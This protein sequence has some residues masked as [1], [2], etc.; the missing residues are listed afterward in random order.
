MRLLP[1]AARWWAV[2]ALMPWLAF[3]ASAHG[4]G[5]ANRYS[6]DANSLAGLIAENYAYLD[7][8]PGGAVLATPQLEAERLGVHD[9]DSL[10]HYAEDVITTL[11]DHH[12]LTGSSFSD[13][14][15]IVPSYSDIWVVKVRDDYVVDAVKEGSIAMRAGVRRGDILLKVDGEPI[16]EAVAGF[17]SRLGLQPAGE[18][19]AYAARVLA[20]GR[21]DRARVLTLSGST[22]ERTV[23][24][25]SLY[26]VQQPRSVLTITSGKAV[27]T[28]RFNNSIGEPSTIAAFD[29]AMEKVPAKSTVVIDLT[30][31]PSGGESSIARAVMSWFVTKPTPYQMHRLPL[32]ERETGIVR[33]WV[34]YVMPRPGKYHPGPVRVKVGRWTG[35]MGEGI[36]IG[37]QAMGKPV[38]GTSMAGLKGAVSDFDLEKTGLRVKFPTEQLFTV[39]GVPRH[40]VRVA[41]CAA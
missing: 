38:C 24:L 37:F 25:A 4:N 39:Q 11:A 9:K 40:N 17:W 14:W 3:S 35:S 21:R 31:T 5:S 6:E 7:D 30:D 33:Q 1:I 16:A 28:I 19:A 36:A 23:T 32:E 26:T 22:G 34:E 13:D 20:A 18:R 29:E 15:A 2:A 12:A 27:I 41:E 10:L 8:L